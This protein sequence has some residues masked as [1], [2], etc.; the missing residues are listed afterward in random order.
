MRQFQMSQF[1]MSQ[2]EMKLHGESACR[3]DS[4]RVLADRRRPS[5]YAAYPG[6]APGGAAGHHVPCLALLPVG[7]AE[8]AGSPRPLVRSYRTVS[9]LPV[10]GS[11]GLDHRCRITVPGSPGHRRSVFCGTFLRVAP[12]GR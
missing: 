9:P 7:F 10:P 6:T 4:V 11:P 2:L 1:E 3:R 5:I 8:R 12:T